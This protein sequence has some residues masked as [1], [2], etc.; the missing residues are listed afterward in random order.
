MPSLKATIFALFAGSALASPAGIRLSE[1]QL[2]YHDMSKRQ[3]EAAAKL[4]L[5]D[6]DILQL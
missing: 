3:N 4:G 1:R 2:H 5:N 6:F